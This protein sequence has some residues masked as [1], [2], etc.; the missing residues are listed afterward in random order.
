MSLSVKVS[1]KHQIAVP[2]AVRRKLAIQAGDRLRVQ[3]LDGVMMLI[4]ESA[5]PI[6][7]LKGL[8]A[9]IWEGVDAQEY[10]NRER[11]DW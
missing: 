7:Q 1:S 2:A 11:D 4:P 10:V 5:D 9:E 6:E 3:V 8:G